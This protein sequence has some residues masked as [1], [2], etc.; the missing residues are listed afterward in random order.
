MKFV[1]AMT[2]IDGEWNRLSPERQ[3]EI[4]GEHEDFKRALIAE[5]KLLHVY[6]LRPRDEARTVRQGVKGKIT[7]TDG[8]F[9]NAS[10][11]IGGFYVIE[12]ASMDEAVEWAR[13]GRFM[14]GANE[15]RQVW[16]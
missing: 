14:I 15:I 6:H 4:L 12:A 5:G 2:D 8:P 9:S 3:Q 13:R 11:Y 10:E 16:E 7:V 1:I